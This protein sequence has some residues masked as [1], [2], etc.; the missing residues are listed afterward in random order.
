VKRIIYLGDWKEGYGLQTPQKPARNG[1]DPELKA[2]LIQSVWL[3]AGIII[4]SGSASF[5][6]IRH[7]V[8]KLPV[9]TT[10]RWVRTLT[11]PIGVEDVLEYLLQAKD[12]PI[13]EESR[14][15]SARRK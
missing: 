9:M 15:T 13:E 1:R 8:Q 11:Q 12:V 5:E 3:R 10:P 14:S 6:I 7:L 4:G 2:D